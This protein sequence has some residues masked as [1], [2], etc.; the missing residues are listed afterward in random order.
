MTDWSRTDVLLLC[1]GILIS[2]CA[3][4]IERQ[5]VRIANESA[6]RH[7]TL[8]SCRVLLKYIAENMQR[9]GEKVELKRSTIT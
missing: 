1:I 3:W 6:M 7:A 4:A 2:G 8:E 5:L 9:G